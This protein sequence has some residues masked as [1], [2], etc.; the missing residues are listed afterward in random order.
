MKHIEEGLL[1]KKL[2]LYPFEDALMKHLKE[3]VQ[4]AVEIYKLENQVR[5]KLKL[6]IKR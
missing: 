3:R 5:I 6:E 4:I 1:N 2:P